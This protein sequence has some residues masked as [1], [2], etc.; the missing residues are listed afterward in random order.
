M[1]NT[2]AKGKAS[3]Q[4]EVPENDWGR[5]LIRVVDENGGHA[6]ST[7]Q[8]IDWPIWSG[9]SKSGTGE[10]AKAKVSGSG[11]CELIV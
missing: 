3:F 11:I 10:T 9:K 8:I 7:T 5:Y 4:F 2:D 6:T 1:L